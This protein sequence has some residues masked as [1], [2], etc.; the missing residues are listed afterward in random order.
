VI[1]TGYD[2]DN[3]KVNVAFKK[4]FKLSCVIQR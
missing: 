3:Q 1:I 2:T 4:I